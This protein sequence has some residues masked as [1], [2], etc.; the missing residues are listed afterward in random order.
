MNMTRVF[1]V[2]L[3]GVKMKKLI[4]TTLALSLL[5]TGCSSDAETTDKLEIV[6]TYYPYELATEEIGGDFVDV[7]SVYPADSDAHSYELTPKQTMEIQDADLVI[8]TN[9]DE[10]SKIYSILEDKDNLL[11]LNPEEN[12]TSE[13]EHAHSH[14]WLSPMEMSD[15][16]T[17]ITNSLIDI[18]PDNK[19]NYEAN[20]STLAS[21][22]EAVSDEYTTFGKE[23]TKPIIAT[24]DA[25]GALLDDYGIK[26]TTLYGQ[27]HDDEPTTKE[28]L[29]VVD[30]IKEQGINTIFV[31][32]DD[33]SNT[34]MRQIADETSSD[35]ETFFTLETESSIK[36]F[37]S[38][39]EFYEYNLQMME[40]S[41]E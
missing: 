15:S 23:Q 18:D 17:K 16:V 27:H 14:A 5:L 33:T 34:V 22:L 10:D 24:H 25:Y 37:S 8:I 41:Q 28:I 11:V 26:F 20:S 29:D 21:N 35:V 30:L 6:T 1:A 12:H 9:P 36:S 7:S 40:M 39:T 13:D 4:S 2:L 3:R 32:Q 19:L 31:E 38:V